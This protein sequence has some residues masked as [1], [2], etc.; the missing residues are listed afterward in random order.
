VH[1]RI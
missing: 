1:R